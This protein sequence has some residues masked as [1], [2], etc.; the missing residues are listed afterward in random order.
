MPH[1]LFSAS[2]RRPDRPDELFADQWD[3][4]VAAG[5]GVSAIP[6]AALTGAKPLQGVPSGA[7]VVYRGWMLN[8]AEYAALSLAVEAC[9]ATMFTSPQQYLL[10]HHL[11]NWYP[12]LADLTP[13]TR[14]YSA[15]ADLAA[16]LRSLGWVA[17]FIKDY[18]KSLK[19]GRGSVVR[20][21]EDA[22]AVVVELR[23][24]RGAIEGGVCVRRF[25][26]FVPGTEVRYFVRQGTV[27]APDGRPVPDL[28]RECAGRIAA[29]FFS[30][31]VAERTDGVL[32]IVE[33][34]D[35]QVSDVVGWSAAA[36][37][38]VWR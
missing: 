15:D 36:F 13:E 14:V 6:D 23:E 8:A 31:D 20:N 19:T 17:Y 28:V 12:P 26:P 18:V 1:F 3:A 30:V 22:P 34:G 9:G 7:T 4:F 21:P 32:R 5:F 38:Q 27:F 35:G 11:P 2:A 16:E 29:P 33:I 24:Y 10:A 37:A 25:E